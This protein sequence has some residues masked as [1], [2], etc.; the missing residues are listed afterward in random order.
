MDLSP[1]RA[2]YLIEEAAS[3]IA[4]STGYNISLDAHT[5]QYGKMGFCMNAPG[6]RHIGIDTTW[7]DNAETCVSEQKFIDTLIA[8]YHECAHMRQYDALNTGNG[9]EVLMALTIIDNVN[10]AY[11]LTNYTNDLRELD[12]DLTGIWQAYR[13][14]VEQ[15]IP[16]YDHL[17]LQ[18]MQR[19][20]R[21]PRSVCENMPFEK[22]TDIYTIEACY[23]EKIMG[24]RNGRIFATDCQYASDDPAFQYLK[25]MPYLANLYRK[26]PVS[27]FILL[28]EF[29]A[30]ISLQVDKSILSEFPDNAYL[31][32]LDLNRISTRIMKCNKST[33][34]R[35]LLF[36]ATKPAWYQQVFRSS[37][38]CIDS[39]LNERN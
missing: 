15:D 25:Q 28:T 1:A 31:A 12:A 14:L 6:V 18:A 2:R 3:A 9:D 20:V 30:A 32:S 21:S 13:F 19:R 17:I 35:D 22:M 34:D 26:I 4:K 39:I 11:Y 33:P 29:L 5:R 23:T 8:L 24:I 7:I 27:D 10:R 37:A 16:E 36:S 38:A